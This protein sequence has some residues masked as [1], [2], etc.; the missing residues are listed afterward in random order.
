AIDRKDP[1]QQAKMLFD[2]YSI[3]EMWLAALPPKE[4]AES[5]LPARLRVSYEFILNKIAH[6]NAFQDTHDL[7][8][9]LKM[10]S[11][12]HSVFHHEMPVT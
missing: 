10:L 9:A 4:M 1:M 12:L 3:V 5:E 11:H 2:A 7:D 6:G 8:E